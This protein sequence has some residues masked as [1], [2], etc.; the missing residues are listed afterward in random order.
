MEL[1]NECGRSQ[2]AKVIGRYWE[3]HRCPVVGRVVVAAAVVKVEADRAH[4]SADVEFA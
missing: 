2:S 3:R 4:F 1:Y